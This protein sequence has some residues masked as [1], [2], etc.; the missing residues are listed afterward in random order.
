MT[1][2]GTSDLNRKKIYYV[3]GD[4]NTYSFN[5][6]VSLEVETQETSELVITQHST[7]GVL[8]RTYAPTVITLTV[9]RI[10]T[11]CARAIDIDKKRGSTVS[12]AVVPDD[13]SDDLSGLGFNDGFV[14]ETPSWNNYAEGED[15]ARSIVFHVMDGNFY[16]DDV[17]GENV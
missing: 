8:Q 11:A 2:L 1:V 10:S 12:L 13:N 4:G 16:N 14:V 6:V 9:K 7:T 5:E 17:D 3:S 15:F